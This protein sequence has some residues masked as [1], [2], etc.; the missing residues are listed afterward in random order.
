MY[1]HKCINNHELPISYIEM[2][3]ANKIVCKTCGVVVKDREG[4]TGILDPMYSHG[5]SLC[6]QRIY[7]LHEDILC[8]WQCELILDTI[9]KCTDVNM[10]LEN[11]IFEVDKL[12][13][14]ALKL[15]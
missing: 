1:L 9:W 7:G 14:K 12:C 4:E 13:Q 11:V 5:C 8:C 6:N 15:K 3:E 10:F 2:H